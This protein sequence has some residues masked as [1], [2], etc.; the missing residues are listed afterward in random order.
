M[1]PLPPQPANLSVS[2]T[3]LHNHIAMVVDEYGGV[4]GLV[5]IEDVIEQIVG[6]IG[7][8]LLYTSRCV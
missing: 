4:C 5:T 8:C 1:E 2:Y 3:H 7:D 6:E